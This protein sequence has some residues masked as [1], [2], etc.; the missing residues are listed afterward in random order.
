MLGRQL[1]VLGVAGSIACELVSWLGGVAYYTRTLI[2]EWSERLRQRKTT[3]GDHVLCS[4]FRDGRHE[5]APT[6]PSTN[7][8]QALPLVVLLDEHRTDAALD[9]IPFL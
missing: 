7:S 6:A 5:I 3:G 9:G 1:R 2:F 8:G 4:H